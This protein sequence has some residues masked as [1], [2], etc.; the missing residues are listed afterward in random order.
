MPFLANPK[1]EPFSISIFHLHLYAQIEKSPILNGINKSIETSEY[2]PS[3]IEK[4]KHLQSN[5]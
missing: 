2:G 1:I 4:G 3:G 5:S